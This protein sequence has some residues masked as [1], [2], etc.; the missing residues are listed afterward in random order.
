M[1]KIKTVTVFMI[2]LIAVPSFCVGYLIQLNI[3][4]FRLGRNAQNPHNK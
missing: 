2:D 3:D 4:A 1:K